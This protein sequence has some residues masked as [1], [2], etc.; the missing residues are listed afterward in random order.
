MKTKLLSAKEARKLTDAYIKLEASHVASF[1]MNLI[2]Y[3]ASNGK[4]MIFV[5]HPHINLLLEDYEFF[6]AL[7]FNAT[8]PETILGWTTIGTISW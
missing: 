6:R 5:D 3:A 2:K 1:Y 4:H 7:G 8:P